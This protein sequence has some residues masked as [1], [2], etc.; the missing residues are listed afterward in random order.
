MPVW[1]DEDVRPWIPGGAAGDTTFARPNRLAVS[2]LVEG[3][4]WARAGGPLNADILLTLVYDSTLSRVRITATGMEV[5]TLATVERSTDQITWTTVRG[6]EALSVAAGTL[7]LDDYEFAPNVTNYYRVRT[8]VPFGQSTVGSISPTLTDVWFKSVARPFLNLAVSLLGNKFEFERRDRGG[9]FPIVGRSL[10]VAVTDVRGSRAYTITIRTDT[11]N[12]SNDLDLLLASG[13][14]LF[15]HAPPGKVVP[16]GGVFVSAG[17]VTAESPAPPAQ[18]R[19]TSVDLTEVAAPAADVVGAT[20]TWQTV[21]N[22][23]ATWADVI[24]AKASWSELLDVVAEP[25]EVVVP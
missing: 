5:F 1:V 13:D 19:F 14:T 4:L 8:L 6:G 7:K 18:L 12:A 2:E 10:P 17:R 25:D 11:D 16:A 9:R 23:Y 20:S 21:I 22:T 24:A 3:D 15:L